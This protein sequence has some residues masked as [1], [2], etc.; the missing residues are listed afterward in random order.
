MLALNRRL[1]EGAPNTS[2]T[3]TLQERERSRLRV[4]LDNGV[5]AGIFLDR[6]RPLRHGDLIG[7][8]SGFVVEVRA[9]AELLSRVRCSDPLQL[10]RVCYHLGNRHIPVQI[11]PGEVSYLRDHVLDE[12]VRGLGVTV[13]AAESRFEP[14]SGAYQSHSHEQ[15]HG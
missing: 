11:Q 4:I 10:A 13:E 7:D 1:T 12:M 2:L 3:M 8:G 5:E 15:G 6:G 14:E 9:A